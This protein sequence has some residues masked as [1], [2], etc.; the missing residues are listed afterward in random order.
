MGASLFFDVGSVRRFAGAV[1][2][3]PTRLHGV[4]S[5]LCSIEP[6][7]PPEGSGGGGPV[8]APDTGV[9]PAGLNVFASPFG[10][11]PM[12]L[13]LPVDPAQLEYRV[14]RRDRFWARAFPDVS[15]SNFMDPVW[16]AKH[17]ITNKG[18]PKALERVAPPHFVEDARNA[19]V[20]ARVPMAVRVS[21]YIF[22]L[23]NW[24]DPYGDPLRRQFI[25][26]RS[27]LLPDH[28]KVGLDSLGEKADSPTDGLTH[29]YN[30]KALF[31]PLKTCPVYCRFCT[32][33]YAIGPDTDEVEKVDLRVD[34]ESWKRAFAYVSSRPE[35][36]DIVVSGGDAYN[37]RP[38]QIT[39]IGEALLSIPH[40]RRF[41]FATK[42]LAVMP[43]KIL[44][45][46]EWV[47]AVT[48]IVEKGRRL[49]K[50]V[51]IHTHFNHP[52]EFTGI[53][54][55]AM[56]VLFERGIVVRNQAVLM[57]GVN[58]SPEAMQLLVRRL[59][60]LHV[61]PYYV[62]VHDL[63]QGVEDLRTSLQTALD[64]SKNTVRGTTAGF[65]TPVFVVDAPDGGGKREAFS[66]EHYDRTTG[67]SV[68]TAHQVKPGKNFLYFDPLRELPEE[69]RRRWDD[70]A[71][72]EVMIR[73]ARVA[74]GLG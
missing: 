25:P 46:Q 15:D 36:V 49:H 58:D 3:I 34:E 69:G 2:G 51:M 33:S 14:F 57:N 60:H 18:L 47:D 35:L 64:L 38:A 21:P 41:R 31:L 59:A 30:D 74:A 4:S 42:G 29:R 67:I 13:R 70:P 11:V 72:H 9:R 40:I 52:N 63:V 71:E 20:L 1:S 53:T 39:S 17:T 44:G 73:E 12:P 6:E 55:D 32:R 28:P 56:D 26:V 37:L 7:G 66:F 68:Y 43:Q 22:S 23:I 61:H 8:A 16:Q 62:Y 24:D 45:D 10:Q 65:N 54:E 5:A 48:R 19:E 27:Q 50:D